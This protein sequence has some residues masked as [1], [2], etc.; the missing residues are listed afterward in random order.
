MDRVHKVLDEH[1]RETNRYYALYCDFSG[2]CSLRTCHNHLTASVRFFSSNK[3][4]GEDFAV[5][6]LD[7]QIASK[8]KALESIW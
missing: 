7:E 8:I 3:L 2:S 6:R 4:R 5:E 1:D